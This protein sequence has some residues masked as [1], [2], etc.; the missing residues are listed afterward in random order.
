MG[1]SA[2]EYGGTVVSDVHI[3]GMVLDATIEVDGEIVVDR[4][5][6]RV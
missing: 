6:V 4:G 2:G 5:S 1:D 3:D